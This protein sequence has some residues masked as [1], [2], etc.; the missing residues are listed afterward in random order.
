MGNETLIKICGITKVD[1][2]LAAADEGADLIGMVFAPSPRQV[3]LHIASTIVNE[4][5]RRHA[6]GPR[7]VGVFVDADPDAMLQVRQATGLDF[8]Q[9]HGSEPPVILPL[10]GGGV[11]RA[12]R[13][14]DTVPD[15]S[16][17][18][19]ASWILFD[20]KSERAAGGT[21]ESF[22]W[23]LLEGRSS[24][25]QPC[26]LAGGLHSGNVAEAIALAHPDGVDVSSGVEASPG[27]KD[28][29]LIREFIREVRKA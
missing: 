25:T 13:V 23:S 18:E 9:L 21:G 4:L 27:V 7:V 17:W 29:K 6:R 26:L 14:A 19:E 3:S 15:A 22:D 2:A 11:I 16:G 5:R 1:D 12:I 8:V 20:T 24:A 28:R 10:L